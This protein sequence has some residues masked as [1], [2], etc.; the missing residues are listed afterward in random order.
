MPSTAFAWI[1]LTATT[2]VLPSADDPSD[3]W[4]TAAP[5]DEVKPTFRYEPEGGREGHG[6]FVIE[7]DDREGLHGSWS[8]T[9]P[10]EGGRTYAVRAYRKTEGV[11]TPRR[12]AFLKLTWLDD[13]G[14]KRP[15]SRGVVR[16][17]LKGFSAQA[18]SEFPGDG[19]T[20]A[21]G[22][23][24][25]SEAYP[26]PEGATRV[27]VE[28]C[29]LWAPPK[30]RVAWSDVAF[31]EVAGIEPRIVRL[32][33]VHYRPKS[34]T[35]A[36]EKRE[37]FEPLIA[38]VARQKADL[39]VLPETL[40]YYNAGKSMADVAEPIPGPSTEYFGELARRYNLYIVAGLVE[41]AD[42]LIYNVAVLIGPDGQIAG[43]YRKV[44]LPTGEVEAGLAPGNDYPV[45]ETRF[46][47]VGMMVCYDGFFPEVAR[48]L[49]TRGAEVIAWPV[50]GCNPE[51]ARARASENHVYL[52]SSTYE[53]I[54]SRWMISAVYD[55]TGEPIAHATL[56][57]T[58]A[59]AEVDL[60]AP[61]RWPS[62]GDFRSKVLRHRPAAIGEPVA[63]GGR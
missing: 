33:T 48:A 54:S 11:A 38:D 17:F 16:N 18:E 56:W 4:T 25:V 37:Q 20:D 15:E 43:K 6:S 28:L 14:R 10:V 61:T 1:I 52:V 22:W 46:G 44:C 24:E 58:T 51:L 42:H 62:L 57:G 31:D 12:S 34:G 60:N 50:W 3:G 21:R 36:A 9:F 26:A 2:Y 30:G 7:A 55:H 32:A 35:T 41:R 53:D 40:T 5:R 63:P 13:Q 39:V 27:R 45:F 23:T 19:A 47:K 59:V 49:T 8:R 29:L